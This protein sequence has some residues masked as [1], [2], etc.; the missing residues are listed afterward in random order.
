MTGTQLLEW[1]GAYPGPAAPLAAVPIGAADAADE[2]MAAG[3]IVGF[4]G[5]D[6]VPYLAATG[7]GRAERR[8]P[9]DRRKTVL[10]SE[11]P[12]GGR[13][14]D[15]EDTGVG[16]PPDIAEA[17]EEIER[18]ASRLRPPRRGPRPSYPDS[19]RLPCPAVLLTGCRAWD[20]IPRRGAACPACGGLPLRAWVY[21]LV[22]DAWGLDHLLPRGGPRPEPARAVEVKP[23]AERMRKHRKAVLA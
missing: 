2:L 6:G 5:T 19:D 7:S 20:A 23:L 21:C 8:R 10:E 12:D 4:R 9:R 15:L 13:L 11:L 1:L 14:T 18:S 17:T 3:R 22:C 16:L